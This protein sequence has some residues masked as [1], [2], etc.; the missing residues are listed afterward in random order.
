M[1]WSPT[2]T[3]K[4]AHA[5]AACD[6]V[7]VRNTHSIQDFRTDVAEFMSRLPPLHHRD[8]Y[9]S[10]SLLVLRLTSVLYCHAS[11]FLFHS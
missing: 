4:V 1:S 8:Q 2:E 3:K 10:Q 7:C 11:T 5:A 9:P 6:C